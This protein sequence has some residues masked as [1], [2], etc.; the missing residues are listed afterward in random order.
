MTKF[1]RAFVLS[2]R[3]FFV[4]TSLALLTL[5]SVVFTRTVVERSHSFFTTGIVVENVS[6]TDSE[7]ETFI[8]PIVE[9][10]D[11]DEVSHRLRGVTAGHEASYAIGERVPVRYRMG[12]PD[13]ARIDSF[14]DNYRLALVLAGFGTVIGLMYL[15]FVRKIHRR[16]LEREAAA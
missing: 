2:H 1:T 15:L 3:L 13:T 6:E 10:R 7:G 9:W 12:A 4:L 8:H 14:A 5:S 11:D 16:I